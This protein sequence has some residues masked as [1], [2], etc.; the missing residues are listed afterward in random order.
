MGRCPFWTRSYCIPPWNGYA[1][2]QRESCA[3]SKQHNAPD[4]K[5]GAFSLLR[6][7]AS[8][9]KPLKAALFAVM[10]ESGCRVG[11][12]PLATGRGRSE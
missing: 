1:A 11:P 9:A 2:N 7:E 3:R 5:S 6:R 4:L 8:D 10:D 12:E